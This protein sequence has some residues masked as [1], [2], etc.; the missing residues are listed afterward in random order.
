MTPIPTTEIHVGR[1][2]KASSAMEG[3]KSA[4]AVRSVPWSM[5][6]ADATHR[7]AGE[8]NRISRYYFKGI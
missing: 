3:A 2:R 7:T 8:S 1:P 5:K 6:I 4:T